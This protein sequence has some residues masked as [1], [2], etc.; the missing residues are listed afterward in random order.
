[1]TEFRGILPAI[2]TPTDEHDRFR[3]EAFAKLIER[4]YEAGVHGLYVCGQT[5][6]G[7]QQ[8][9]EQRKQVAE[10]A[11]RLSPRGKSVIV[12]VG[13]HSTAD[14]LELAR[15]ASLIGAHAISSLPPAVSYSFDEIREYYRALAAASDVPLLIYYFPSLAPAIRTTD[16]VLELCEL[17][18]VAGLKFTDSDFFRLWAIRKRGF[19]VFNGSDEMLV[20]GLIMGAN[21]GIG[22]IYNLVPEQ[23][24]AL[25]EHT[26]AGR[27]EDARRTQ[28]HINELIEVIL[29]Y[30]VNSAVKAILQWSGMDCGRAIAPRR[31][32]TETEAAGLQTAISSTVL[33]RD[34]LALAARG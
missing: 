6:E 24:V 16:Q 25:Y 4:V 31:P 2:V 32:L 12:H 28:Y 29:R 22:S 3:P 18:N 21:G 30:P 23:F 8:P 33:G 34:L 19:V 11:V 5:G 10:A 20:A 9:I 7:M 15:H 13:A 17:P 27:W 1:M 26:V 14:A